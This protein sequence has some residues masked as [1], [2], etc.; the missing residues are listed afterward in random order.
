GTSAVQLHPREA[1]APGCTGDD[2]VFV[3]L[4]L[5]DD[6]G[7][8]LLRELYASGCR[9]LVAVSASGRASD[10]AWAERAGACHVLFR[11]LEPAAV[12]TCLAALYPER[13]RDA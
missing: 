12:E 8:R 2:A 7:F 13:S 9:K 5:R 3:S 10:Q 11:P 4:Q 1:R 6:N